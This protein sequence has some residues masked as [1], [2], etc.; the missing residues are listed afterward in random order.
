MSAAGAQLSRSISLSFSMHPPL[1][2]TLRVQ[3]KGKKY[4]GAPNLLCLPCLLP[5][6]IPAPGMGLFL[7][8]ARG[9][10]CTCLSGHWDM[11]RYFLC[12]RHP[13]ETC[14]VDYS[15]GQSVSICSLHRNMGEFD[16]IVHVNH[17]I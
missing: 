12:P 2:G 6:C 4:W 7:C 16:F 15:C 5:C 11:V 8:K 17:Y 14:K 1:R 13:S 9:L 10:C 3:R